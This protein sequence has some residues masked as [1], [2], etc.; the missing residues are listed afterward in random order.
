MK[1]SNTRKQTQPVLQ[2]QEIE[3]I[4]YGIVS[5]CHLVTQ[6]NS[7][8]DNVLTILRHQAIQTSKHRTASLIE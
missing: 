8:A 1:I 4:S 6:L 5:L 3:S 7:S 2:A